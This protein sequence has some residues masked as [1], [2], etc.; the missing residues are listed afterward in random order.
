MTTALVVTTELVVVGGIALPAFGV[1]V[2]GV[3]SFFVVGLGL[4]CCFA[5]DTCVPFARVSMFVG[6]RPRPTV[7]F[8][9][10]SRGRTEAGTTGWGF[11]YGDKAAGAGIRAL[12][13]AARVA[14]ADVLIVLASCIGGELWMAEQ[15]SREQCGCGLAC[16]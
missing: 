4:G 15:A 9:G 6:F 11:G 12:V 13:K 16:G 5:N 3:S 14:I 10:S 1:C 7:C 8:L 2:G